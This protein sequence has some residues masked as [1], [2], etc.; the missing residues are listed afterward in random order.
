MD[1]NFRVFSSYRVLS[2]NSRARDG[3]ERLRVSAQNFSLSFNPRARDGRE[4]KRVTS[5]F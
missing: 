5:V 4:L 3:R 2:F 1:A